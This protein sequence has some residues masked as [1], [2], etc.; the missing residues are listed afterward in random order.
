MAAQKLP[1]QIALEQNTNDDSTAYGKWFGKTYSTSDTLSLRGLIE[2]V[3]FDQ[4][5]YS[6]DIIEGVI[7]R[8]TVTM[9]ELLQ[10]GESVKWDGLGTFTPYVE[11]KGVNRYDQY[12]VN[13]HVKG[14]HVRFIPENSKGEQLTSR[15]FRDQCTLQ[16]A[17]LWTKRNITVNNKKKVIREF[18]TLQDYKLNQEHPADNNQ[19]G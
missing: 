18:Y 16:L 6:R 9:T 14:I 19:G 7:D 5:V 15:A 4:S 2:R 11:S 3:A 17:G 1:F 12:D 8:L 10:S 13:T